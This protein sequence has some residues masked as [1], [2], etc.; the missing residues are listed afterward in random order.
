MKVE[1]KNSPYLELCFRPTIATI[2]EARRLVAALYA[3]LVSDADVAQRVAL[4]THELLENA[5]KYSIDGATVLRIELSHEKGPRTVTVETRNATSPD[6]RALLADAFAEMGRF[7]DSAEFFQ[8][9]MKRTRSIRH[10]SG[11]GLARIWAEAEMD[12]AHS[13]VGDEARVTATLEIEENR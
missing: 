7:G 9:A 6:R 8:F 11:L 1:G 2:N 13:F 4:T 3:P 10:G 12:L 5:L